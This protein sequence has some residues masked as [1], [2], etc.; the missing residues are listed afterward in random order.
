MDAR[1]NSTQAFIPAT[2]SARAVDRGL[3]M[4]VCF[5]RHSADPEGRQLHSEGVEHATC[6]IVRFG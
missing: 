1:I 5:V 2:G 6:P 4:P 3:R